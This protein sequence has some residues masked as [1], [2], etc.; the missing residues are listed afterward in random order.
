M[1][2]GFLNRSSNAAKVVDSELIGNGS[3]LGG[4]A[5]KIQSIDGKIL[6]RDGKPMVARRCVRFTDKTN[7]SDC[8][9]GRNLNIVSSMAEVS[10]H[11]VAQPLK[12]DQQ[13]V[14][15]HGDGTSPDLKHTC[16]MMNDSNSN[17]ND[18]PIMHK[19]AVCL[20]LEAID[21]I[22]ARFVNTLYGYPVG[23]RLAFPMVEN[24]VKHTWAKFGLK[25]VMMHHG[26]FMF[27]FET[28]SG[29]E[30]VI[31][32]GPWRIQLV[33]IV[34]N[35]WMPNTLLKREKVSH[36]PLWVKLHNVPIVAYSK[37]GLDLILAKVGR[38]MRLDAH[39]NFICLNSWGRSDY[40]RAL[41]EVSAEKPL[42]ESIDIDIPNE[43]GKGYTTV[44]V[45]VEFEWKPPRCGLCNIFDHLESVCPMKRG[46]DPS[47]ICDLHADGK[48]DKQPVQATGKKGKGKQVGNQRYIK[49]YRV[50]IPK[51]KLVYRAVI[52][53]QGDKNVAS[54]MGQSLDTTKKPSPSDS[55]MNGMSSF[56]NDDINL[57]EL[58]T[59][60]DKSMQ[61]ESVLEEVENYDI[62]S[63]T[64][65]RIGKTV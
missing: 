61:E 11:G 18:S 20:P 60:V 5:S 35:V 56:I 21:E 41:V 52:K 1:N 32:E 3:L 30:K 59:F 28:K 55:S 57:E 50:N 42:V 39:T 24:Y 4:L 31:E 26:L 37:V 65:E 23:K 9:D 38:L 47:M 27:Q 36:V 54:N 33:P 2:K 45:R 51:S 7:E 49:G 29:M 12:A 25:R 8:G 44:N 62:N 10:S 13:K 63:C 22:K 64:S 46:A 6:G 16:P 14:K 17:T 40:A 19:S 53:P 48:K 58:R 15:V 43:D 34:L